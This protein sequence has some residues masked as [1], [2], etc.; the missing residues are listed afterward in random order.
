MSRASIEVFAEIV[1]PFTHVGLRRIV[2]RRE[3]A[4]T[5]LPRL[6]LRAWP[7]EWVNGTPLDGTTVARHVEELREQVEPGLFQGFDPAIMPMTSIPA[8]EVA[9]MAAAAGDEVGERV[10]RALRDAFFEEGRDISDPHVLAE[11]R[12]RFD[13]GE[14]DDSARRA[15]EADYAEGCHRGVRGSPEYFLDGRGY[16]CPAL[17][18][19]EVDGSLVIEGSGARFDEFLDVCFR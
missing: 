9:A 4:G 18:L 13:L 12:A 11:I 3:A 1:C 17:E 19:Q 10:G 7:L 14:P 8:F 16:F 6:R 2:A 15:V 5:D